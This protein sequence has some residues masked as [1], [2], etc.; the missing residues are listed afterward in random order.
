MG[1]DIWGEIVTDFFPSRH[2]CRS[3]SRSVGGGEEW[4]GGRREGGG[5]GGGGH[6]ESHTFS[7][8]CSYV[9]GGRLMS[10]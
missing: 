6:V 4:E 10:A 9:C 3:V 2:T 5:R 7:P 1:S 8:G